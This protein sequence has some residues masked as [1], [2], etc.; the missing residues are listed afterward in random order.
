[1]IFQQVDCK[2]YRLTRLKRII[3]KVL[4]VLRIMPRRNKF[5]NLGN[6][7]TELSTCKIN[8]YVD[9]YDNFCH[10]WVG[11]DGT[12][13]GETRNIGRIKRIPQDIGHFIV[14]E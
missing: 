10:Q 14:I 8:N 9:I 1:M 4:L 7:C 3:S 11:R 12:G 5:S 6:V 2:A 13:W